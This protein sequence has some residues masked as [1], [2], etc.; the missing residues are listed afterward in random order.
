MDADS[1]PSLV[2]TPPLGPL[3]DALVTDTSFLSMVGRAGNQKREAVVEY[4]TANDKTLYLTERVAQELERDEADEYGLVDIL[5]ALKGGD[6]PKGSSRFRV[7]S[8]RRFPFGRGRHRYPPNCD[9]GR[10]FQRVKPCQWGLPPRTRRVG[11]WEYRVPRQRGIQPA[12]YCHSRPPDAGRGRLVS[13]L[14]PDGASVRSTVAVED[15]VPNQGRPSRRPMDGRPIKIT[16]V[17]SPAVLSSVVYG[18]D[19]RIH[20]R[21]EGRGF[22]LVLP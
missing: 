10:G 12:W 19:Y 21:P 17:G 13:A 1:S 5:P 20:P 3:P 4:V 22:L 15:R 14:L 6:S 2:E 9:R 18:T 8:A 11:R 7:S 16:D